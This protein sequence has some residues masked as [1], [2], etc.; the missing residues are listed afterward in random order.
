MRSLGPTA[1]RNSPSATTL[2]VAG[3]STFTS[4]PSAHTPAMSVAPTPMA[5]APIAP[6][7][8]VWLSAPTTTMPGTHVPALGQDLVADASLVRADVVEL[9]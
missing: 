4:R 1:G 5:M 8:L 6:W 9:A 3:T 2:M 7:L